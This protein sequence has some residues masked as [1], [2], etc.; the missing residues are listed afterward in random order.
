[1]LARLSEYSKENFQKTVTRSGVEN[2][3]VLLPK[4]K[5]NATREKLRGNG[6]RNRESDL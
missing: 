6:K 1:M 3:R 2:A 4:T 5:G